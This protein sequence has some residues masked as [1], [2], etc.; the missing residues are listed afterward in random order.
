MDTFKKKLEERKK[1]VDKALLKYW[2]KTE[3]LPV[4]RNAWIKQSWRETGKVIENG[5]KR[6][7]PVMLLLMYEAVSQKDSRKL[8]RWRWLWS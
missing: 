8:C 7:R 5:G 1:E 2:R 4:H 6:L 3:Q